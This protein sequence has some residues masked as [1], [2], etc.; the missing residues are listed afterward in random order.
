MN[1]Y[2]LEQCVSDY[3]KDIFSFCKV[4]T[5]NTQEAEELYQDTFLKATEKMNKIDYSNNPKSYLISIAL[6]LWKNRN[7]KYAWR[8]RIAGTEPLDEV[9]GVSFDTTD[10]L[11]DEKVI[12]KELFQVVRK[13]VAELEEKYR[14]PV[15]LYYTAELSVAEISRTLKLPESTVKNRLFQARKK[16]KSKL[17][18]VLDEK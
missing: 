1:F 13:G 18:V 7:R 11:P 15:Y 16:L 4:L 2:Q 12:Q 6:R 5:H 8:N 9:Y 14:I 10:M 17:E 3:G